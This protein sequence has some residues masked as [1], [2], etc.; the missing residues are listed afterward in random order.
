MK[1]FPVL[2]LTGVLL[3]GPGSARAFELADMNCDGAVNVF[4]IDP[5]VMALTDPVTYA[6][7]FPA[8]D[9]LLADVNHDGDVNVFDI[10]PFV[11]CLTN[12]GGESPAPPPTPAEPAGQPL[13]APPPYG[14]GRAF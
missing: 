12:G 6:A 2:L 11:T 7:E 5:F 10:D 14:Y 8:C 9:Y 13:P 4:D 1:L 3:V